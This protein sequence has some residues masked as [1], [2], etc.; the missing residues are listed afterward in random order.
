MWR[1]EA[2]EL[3]RQGIKYYKAHKMLKERF[4]DITESMVRR[5]CEKAFL[6]EYLTEKVDIKNLDK[7]PKE[8]DTSPDYAEVYDKWTGNKILRFGVVS[9]THIGS[10][11]QQLTLLNEAYR[12][13]QQEN[14]KTVYHVGD[15]TEGES[16]R[17]GHAY[18]CFLHG[19]D[20][21][22]DYIIDRYP[23][24]TD[25]TTR[26]I[27]GNHDLSITKLSGVDIGKRIAEKRSDMEYLGKLNAKVYLTPNCVIELNHPLD[28]SS[29][30]YSYSL[31]KYA[32]SMQG[33]SKP[34]ILLTGHYH[35]MMY[36]D[37]RNINILSIPSLQS[38]TTWMRGKRLPAHIGFFIITVHVDEQG[39]I[40][41]FQPEHF[42]FYVWKEKDY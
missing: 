39:T 14:I 10:K 21:I 8:I 30:A 37:Y 41:R 12:V 42:P 15:L 25:I 28:G 35:K 4:P 18:E 6:P 23:K 11:F 1:S 19:G 29:Y 32:D 33:G 20:E 34:N 38:Q 16:M 36:L 17:Q 27:T 9:D 13:F 2:R 3:R 24:Q 40:K 26:F 22:T 7:K 5:E 31:Q